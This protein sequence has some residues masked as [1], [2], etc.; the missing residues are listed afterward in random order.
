MLGRCWKCDYAN[1]PQEVTCV[2][3]G[4]DLDWSAV[5]GDG[6][7]DRGQEFTVGT[8]PAEGQA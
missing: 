7:S 3:C 6:G 1:E 4:S 8:A 5:L 2:I